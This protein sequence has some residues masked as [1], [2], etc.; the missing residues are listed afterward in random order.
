MT[1]QDRKKDRSEKEAKA[2]KRQER[3]AQALRDNLRRRKQGNKP[4]KTK[5][6]A[7]R[8]RSAGTQERRQK[9]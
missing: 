3:V 4:T 1:E 7:V 6:S 2:A 9:P 5:T 8:S